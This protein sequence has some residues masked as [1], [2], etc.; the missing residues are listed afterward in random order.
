MLQ[1]LL[2][3]AGCAVHAATTVDALAHSLSP[4][5]IALVLLVA[6]SP[7]H[8][9]VDTLY[10]LRCLGYRVPTLLL[11]HELHREVRRR[12]FELGALDVVNLPADAHALL[13]RL[14]SVLS[15]DARTDVTSEG[16]SIS[17]GGFLL[18]MRTATLK[19]AGGR[20]VHLTRREGAIL[21]LLMRVPGQVVGRQD[22]LDQVWGTDYAGD[23]TAL[24]VA[25]W[26]LRRK[27]TYLDV[28]RRYVQTVPKR[29]YLFDA[30]LVPRSA[31]TEQHGPPCVLVV[32]DDIAI[33]TLIKEA[34]VEAGY[35]VVWSMG[36]EGVMLARR[37]QPALILLDLMMPGMDGMEVRRH[38]KSNPRTAL[39]PVIAMSAGSNLLAHA[40][41]MDADDYL[42][43]PFD[44][45]EL[46]LRI[47]KWVRS[48][49]AESSAQGDKREEIAGSDPGRLL[50]GYGA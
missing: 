21:A 18:D 47:Q 45:D 50:P 13:A 20:L 39:I 28:S 7:S 24:D 23:G 25:V 30:R 22:L 42:A 16:L 32:D 27:L 44:L 37:L 5:D 29:G 3:E 11:G 43:K 8:D 14:K 19:A 6:A 4:A 26:R 1:F 15:S 12:A 40:R 35:N 41:E 9:D 34:L 31:A 49:P 17:A 36:A 10:K 2:M 48:S 33:A 46:T 38:L